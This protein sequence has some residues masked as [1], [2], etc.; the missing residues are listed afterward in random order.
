MNRSRPKPV[1]PLIAI[2]DLV[3]QDA[4]THNRSLINLFN[5]IN[6]GQL[7]ILHPRLAVVVTVTDARGSF[8]LEMRIRHVNKDE[9]ILRVQGEAKLADP[10]VVDELVFDVRGLTF[11]DE[12]KHVVEVLSHDDLIGHRWF[13]VTIVT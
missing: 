1:C 13:T 9:P 3:I 6:V 5:N 4:A 7:P 11:K 8:P 10:L 2:C 12:G